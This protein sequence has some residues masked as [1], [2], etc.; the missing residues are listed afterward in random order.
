MNKTIF[1]LLLTVGISNFSLSQQ[2]ANDGITY[3]PTEYVETLLKENDS[4]RITFNKTK[5]KLTK[6]QIENIFSKTKN[7]QYDVKKTS[8]ALELTA[9]LGEKWSF[10]E[11]L[12]S[13]N[14][15][16]F[17]SIDEFEKFNNSLAKSESASFE[18]DGSLKKRERTYNNGTKEIIE[19]DANG[20][21]TKT[22]I[23]ENGIETIEKIDDI[24]KVQIVKPILKIIKE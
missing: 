19:K 21:Y 4:L 14:T 6:K 16:N 24:S 17:K 23:D 2:K 12:K 20:N 5:D 3:V 7:K 8:M 10:D 1:I 13:E 18:K 11:T 15:R 22:I 9:L